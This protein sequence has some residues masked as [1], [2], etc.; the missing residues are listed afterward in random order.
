MVTQHCSTGYTLH[1]LYVYINT[2]NVYSTY[3]HLDYYSDQERLVHVYVIIT[4]NYVDCLGY[5]T[6]DLDDYMFEVWIYMVQAFHVIGTFWK[7]SL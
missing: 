1:I 6:I 2:Y 7:V 5:R 3:V 4:I